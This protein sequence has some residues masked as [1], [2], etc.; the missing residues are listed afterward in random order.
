MF[1]V[2][3]T[4]LIEGSTES[5]IQALLQTNRRDAETLRSIDQNVVSLLQGPFYAGLKHLEL[6]GRPMREPTLRD[7]DL[8]DARRSFIQALG[9]LHRHPG[10]S[11]WAALHLAMT[12]FA[13][14]LYVDAEDHLEEAHD[15]F[16]H[17]YVPP[18]PRHD[19]LTTLFGR[20][21]VDQ[22][23]LSC[24]AGV[25]RMRLGLG[26]LPTAVPHFAI[27][28][29]ALVAT[30][31]RWR[32][33]WGDLTF[34]R[35]QDVAP[36]SLQRGGSRWARYGASRGILFEIASRWPST[37]AMDRPESDI[38][39]LLL[40]TRTQ[41]L[42]RIATGGPMHRGRTAAMILA[43]LRVR[44]SR[45]RLIPRGAWSDRELAV[46]R[47]VALDIVRDRRA[48]WPVQQKNTLP[49][50]VRSLLWPPRLEGSS[51]EEV[52]VRP[53]RRCM[54][55]ALEERTPRRRP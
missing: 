36:S 10:P 26:A 42:L 33:R 28:D 31:T 32:L 44:R 35:T 54:P 50:E 3:V 9:N 24:L 15:W 29:D 41:E 38:W 5:V 6:A 37:P 19:A 30:E 46:V 39:D 53:L 51:R 20:P 14:R 25:T 18:K 45:A 21:A 43:R 27:A 22:A 17:A 23:V 12:S 8:H 7:Q 11:G 1:D 55:R 16:A 13:L 2:I 49:M 4:A 52:V 40:R 47:R 48:K 34:R